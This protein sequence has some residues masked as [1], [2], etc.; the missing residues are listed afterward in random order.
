MSPLALVTGASRGIGRAIARALAPAHSLVLSGRDR[1]ALARVSAELRPLAAGPIHTIACE[2]GDPADRAR[3]LDDLTSLCEQ[4]GAPVQVLVNNA[5]AA[6]SAS[7]ARTDDAQWAALLEL[8][9][10]APFALTRA[11]VPGMIK[12]GWGRVIAIASTAA[13]KGYAYTA[14]YTASKAGLLGLTRALAVELASKGVTVNAVC[15][16]FTDTDI[17]SRAVDNIHA[18]TGRS[19]DEARATLAAFSPQGRLR[20]PDE[21]AT[22]V[23]FLAS[24]DAGGITGQALAIDG[25]ETA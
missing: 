4:L 1:D 14:A 17:V 8:N 13:L 19:A 20:D 15:P 11:L 9:L 18:T 22:L 6:G 3:L 24:P 7:L 5:G 10:T 23:A 16:G 12:A 2:L 21:I 25:G